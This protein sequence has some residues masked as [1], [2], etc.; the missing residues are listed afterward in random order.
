MWGRRGTAGPT[1]GTKALAR[2]QP[3]WKDKGV[4][5]KSSEKMASVSSQEGQMPKEQ[6]ALFEVYRGARGGRECQQTLEE[7]KQG[8][9]GTGGLGRQK[10]S[11]AAETQGV[12]GARA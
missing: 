10:E 12:G 8:E 1:A 3:L 6:L 5:G 4:A 2:G 9:G 7:R 11:E